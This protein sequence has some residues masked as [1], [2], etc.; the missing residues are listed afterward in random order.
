MNAHNSSFTHVPAPPGR[1]RSGESLRRSAEELLAQQ[2]RSQPAGELDP[3]AQ[4]IHEL[5]VYQ[6]ELEI[7][8]E[9]LRQAQEAHELSSRRHRDL[10]DFAPLGYFC[11][12]ASGAILEANLA[13]AELL[14][15]ERRFLLR[16]PFT[17]FMPPEHHEAFLL[18]RRGVVASAC[19]QACQLEL[20]RRDGVSFPV[21]VEASVLLDENGAPTYCAAVI[22]L[23]ERKKAEEERD[24]L[25]A[26]LRKSQRMEALGTLAGGIAHDFNNI[27]TPIFAHGELALMGLSEESPVRED[28]A[29]LLA[30][31]ERAAALVRQILSISRKD[32]FGERAPLDLSGIVRDVSKLLRATIPAAVQIR[33]TV[34]HGLGPVFGNATELFQVILNLCTNARDAMEGGGGVLTLSLTRAQEFGREKDRLRLTVSDTGSG[35]P[36][37]VLPRIFDPY[38]TTKPRGRGTGLGLAVASGIVNTMGGEIRV[39]S[40]PDGGTSFDVL[41][42]ECEGGAP[43][44]PCPAPGLLKGNGERVLVVDDESSVVEALK[45]TLPVMGYQVTGHTHPLHAFEALRADPAA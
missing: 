11:L 6:A 13:G 16:K 4:L 1:S 22:D 23:T 33:E 28:V 38:F 39:R 25:E 15:V 35:I 21:Q 36:P 8:N 40:V 17:V 5:Q 42:P 34:D 7:Q 18:H 43:A 12:D 37:D 24:R 32:E 9:E 29:L 31:A 14:G 2:R 27:L 10:F 3:A 26:T 45:K 19:R 30:S 44:P 41:L 20:R